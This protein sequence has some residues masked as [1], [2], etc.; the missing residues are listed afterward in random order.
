MVTIVDYGM[1]NLASIKNMLKKI[2]TG[3][4]ITSDSE[5]LKKATKIILY[6]VVARFPIP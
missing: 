6:F 1:G 3:A 4:E 5:V 2:G